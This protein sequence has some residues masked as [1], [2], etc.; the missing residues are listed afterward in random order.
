MLYY[1][2]RPLVRITLRIFFSKIYLHHLDRIPLNRPVLIASNHPSAF[3]EACLLATHFP[4]SLHFLVRGDIFINRFVV[5]LLEQ[6]HLTPIYRFVDGFKNLRSNDATFN[7]CYDRLSNKEIIVV[8]AEGNTTQEK[9]LRPIQKGL[10]R[11]AFGAMDKYPDMDLCVVPLGVNYTHPNDFRSEVFVETGLPIELKEYYLRYKEDNNKAVQELTQAVE[12]SMKPLVIHVE[13]NE[14]LE[15]AEKLWRISKAQAN[16][17][18]LP[19]V[20]LAGERFAKDKMISERVNH[21]TEE[22]KSSLNQTL[23]PAAAKPVRH[24]ESRSFAI[25]ALLGKYINYPPFMI[26]MGI[27]ASKVKRIEFY[28][29]V[30]IGLGMFLY[31]F[32]MLAVFILFRAIGWSGLLGLAI[33]WVSGICYLYY[34]YLKDREVNLA[35]RETY[36]ELPV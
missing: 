3:L 1:L 23:D 24:A 21:L 9:R 29:S 25:P 35:L 31:L 26:A 28:A 14:D 6:L 32:Y 10:A 18:Y 36:P 19:V 5:A 2:L 8:Y 22:E 27:A 11:I 34:L 7:A 4:K 33:L 20:E 16:P 12:E 15:L 30:L 17:P 13:K